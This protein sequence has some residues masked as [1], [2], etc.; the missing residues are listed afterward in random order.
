MET[1]NVKA[2]MSQSRWSG[3]GRLDDLVNELKRQA[4]ARFDFCVDARA[5]RVAKS[6]VYQSFFGDHT[7]YILL[8]ID[9]SAS[10]YMPM[11]GYPLKKE[12]LFQLARSANPSIPTKFIEGLTTEYP[13]IAIDLMN[14]LLHA[15]ANRH[16]IRILDNEV[17]AF[18]SDKYRVIDHFGIAMACLSAAQNSGGDIV[19]C[20]LTD[21]KM[22]IKFTSRKIY[23]A[24]NLK[25]TGDKGSWYAG[26][27]GNQ[28]WLSKVAAKSTGELPG[29]PGTVHP[30]ITV[31]N[32]ETGFGGFNVRFGIL[33]AICYNLATV[34]QVAQN[35]HLGARIELG[36]YSPETVSAES[37]AILLK[38][39]DAVKAAFNEVTFRRICNKL[40]DAQEREI[41]EPTD[42]VEN[43]VN[44]CKLSDEDEKKI[45]EYFL[46][47]YDQTHFGLGQAVARRAQDI[48][49]ADK[50]SQFEQIAGN[51]MTG[52]NYQKQLQEV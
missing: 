31:S 52:M 48:E 28:E 44:I 24:L 23:D 1:Q 4:S 43:I 38:A 49:N 16:F 34:E 29:G 12:A 17:R 35:I 42:A 37:K 50:A 6:P 15:N 21:R 46:R 8:P 10:D 19:E 2:E 3:R 11:D 26:G 41:E 27:L 9:S 45:L 33:M 14:D 25:R 22:R 7:P 40:K 20:T 5:I 51:I 30:L 32:S 47:D 36:V 18:L 13:S 39:G